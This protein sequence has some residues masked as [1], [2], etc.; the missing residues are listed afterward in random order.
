M[1]ALLALAAA[2]SLVATGLTTAAAP[3][4]AVDTLRIAGANR[5]A[6]SV[7][8]SRSLGDITG[9]VVYLASGVK[10]P[11][12]LA[13]GP[14]VAAEGG[15]L[16]LTAPG[17]L[18]A[19][20]ADRISELA[21]AE[22]VAV[23]S[24]ASI[25]DTVLDAAVAAAAVG[26][27]EVERTRLG[28]TNRVETSLLLLDRLRESGPVDAAWIVSG[29]TFPDALVAA[30]VAGRYGEAVILDHHAPTRAGSDAWLA[31]V[32]PEVHGL[33]LHI[34][35]GAPSV[36]ETDQ[37]GLERAG[38]AWTTR[39]AGRDRY[40]TAKLINESIPDAPASE[41]MLLATGQNFP[42]A[43][44]GA[45]LSAA[46]GTP[47]YLS[48]NA[49]H[50][51]IGAMLRG[52]VS[53]LGVRTVIGLGSSATLSDGALQL[54]RCTTPLREQIGQVYGRFPMQRHT[55]TGT[56]VIDLGREVR[57]GQVIVRFDGPRFNAVHALDSQQRH[58]DTIAAMRSSGTSTGLVAPYGDSANARFLRVETQGS[59]ALEVRDLT[60]APV[61]SGS[62]T[63]TGSGVY[64]YDGAARAV[65]LE[66]DASQG[67]LTTRELFGYREES[68]PVSGPLTG[69][70][71]G[72]IHDGPSVIAV[73]ARAPWSLQL[74]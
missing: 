45:V 58:L 34:A 36:S 69:P 73:N 28:G 54:N 25:A 50:P 43:L 72:S 31:R 29:A 24:A 16:L 55:G 15:D 57:Y 48:P 59:W 35:G 22:I 41:D 23:G 10:F 17:Q 27:Q 40:E 51:A 13:A 1:R 68:T 8:I 63:G 70:W 60:S 32:G 39:Y 53:R 44:A 4:A 37:A 56:T 74:R 11:D 67:P 47:M 66:H 26:G 5:F 46:T 2:L 38:A 18:P 3:A 49:C 12:A 30:S 19:V 65:R 62:I 64:L 52:E 33:G 9:G 7:E 42:D 20:V 14:V 6:T 71:T 21:P 61:L